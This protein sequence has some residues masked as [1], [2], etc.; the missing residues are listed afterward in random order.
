MNYKKIY[1][2]L[3][4]K[5]TTY[6]VFEVHHKVPKC[7]GG[8]DSSQNLVKLSHRE[9]WLAHK[10]LTKIYP[11]NNKL[12][13]AFAAMS[14]NRNLTSRQF[15]ECKAAAQLAKTR[16]N[17][18]RGDNNIMRRSKELREF[19]SKRMKENNPMRLYPEK[20]HTAYPVEV[21]F[22]DGSV[23]RYAYGKLAYLDI[24]MSRATWINGIRSNKFNKRWNICRVLKG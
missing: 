19:H 15:D 24:G 10:L 17:S 21:H 6:Q 16:C 23:K 14:M 18:N 9:H 11:D 3:V 12:W 2:A 22:S 8:D 5:D 7:M 1:E 4:S 20:N 13:F